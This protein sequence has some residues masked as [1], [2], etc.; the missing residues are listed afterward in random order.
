[1]TGPKI[2][3]PVSSVK[4]AKTVI[5]AGADIVYAGQK[6]W[7]LRPDMFELPQKDLA[8][9]IN[10]AKNKKKQIF[11]AFNCLYRSSEIPK[12]LDLVDF[13]S[14]KGVTG[15]ILSEIGLINAVKKRHPRLLINVSVQASASS[16]IDVDYYKHLGVDGVV[17]PRNFVD[18]DMN[19]VKALC[20]QG[21]KIEIFAIG[22]DSSH[23]DGRCALSAYA[24]QK[25]VKDL[26]GREKLVL[27]N[28]NRCGYCFLPCK[29][30]CGI[31]GKTARHLKRGDLS[32]HHRAPD[33]V[34]AGVEIFKIQ[35]REF[36]LP[37]VKKMVSTFRKL[38]NSRNDPEEFQRLCAVL[39]SMIGL[40]QRIA[41]NH[42]W[43]LA[44]SSSPGWKKIRPFIETP[45]DY[46]TSALWLLTGK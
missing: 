1:M 12:V 23:Y 20:R 33:L 30:E 5:D 6:G 21:V 27:G 32:L 9:V 18:L 19:N 41:A 14:Q 17:L 45:W 44:K 35:G 28:A 43:L 39:D 24:F 15:V 26:F 7:S 34:E 25:Q 22:D 11:I 2:L 29:R 37:L 46:I 8:Q 16:T 38:L 13:Y 42:L 36:P 40:K 31:K 3:A 10:L 4:M